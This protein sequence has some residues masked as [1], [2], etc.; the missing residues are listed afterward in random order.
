M[1]GSEKQEPG[2]TTPTTFILMGPAGCG[3]TT[4]GRRVSA[5]L[6]W[7]FYEGDEY[8][9]EANVAKMSRGVGLTDEDRRPWIR[10]LAEALNGDPAPARAVACSSLSAQVRAWLRGDLVGEVRFV[11]LAVDA[12][13]LRRRLESRRGHYMGASMVESQLRALE[14]PRDALRIAADGPPDEVVD[15]VVSA[16]LEEL[17]PCRM[18]DRPG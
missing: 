6:G 7:P 10:A 18:P 1:I 14:E 13:E 4:V 12:G 5:E 2:A 15:E 16:V 8:H 3:K 9:S 17:V 11:Y